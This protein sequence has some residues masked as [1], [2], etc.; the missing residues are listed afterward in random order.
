MTEG[1]A[2]T[3]SKLSL[4]QLKEFQSFSHLAHRRC[5]TAI[6]PVHCIIISHWLVK[7]PSSGDLYR[8]LD[9]WLGFSK[10][11]LSV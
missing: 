3:K 7:L 11:P 4:C 10:Y 5:L 6:Y 1:K 8:V 2:L 9:T